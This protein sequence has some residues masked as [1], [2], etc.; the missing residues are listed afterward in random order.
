[1][2]P[3]IILLLLSVSAIVKAQEENPLSIFD[4]LI[5][6]T[7]AIEAKWGNGSFFKQ[8]VSF[9]YGLEGNAVFAETKGF[10]DT[11]GEEFGD[12]NFGVRKF[13]K[14]S[15]K[16]LFWEFDTFGGVTTGEVQLKGKNTWYVYEYGGTTL[17][18][19]W[20]YVD[21]ETYIYKVAQYTDGKMGDV[22]LEGVYKL[23]K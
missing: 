17:A 8:E 6:K 12:R 22:Y 5:G 15:D 4:A 18:D 1:M 3:L 21:E 7:W 16:I 13:D 19:I 11:E 10:V 2:R 23:M 20:E 9:R 14:E